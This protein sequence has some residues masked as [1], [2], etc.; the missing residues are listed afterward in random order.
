M[1]SNGRQMRVLAWNMDHW[2]RR[3][4]Q[5]EAAW[6]FLKQQQPAVALLQEA[7]P[8]ERHRA[9]VYNEDTSAGRRSWGTAV[10]APG[11]PIDAVTSV[12]VTGKTFQLIGT[13][14]G[15]LAI[16]TV[17][18]PS[19]G[20]VT[21]VSIY[22]FLDQGWAITSMHHLLSDLAPLLHARRN[23]LLVM[24]GDLN[25]STQLSKPWRYYHRN[26]FERIELFGMVNLL[27]ATAPGRR[28]LRD[29]PGEDE[30]CQHVQTHQHP[31]SQVP[32]HNDYLYATRKLAERLTACGVV[33]AGDP[34]WSLSDHRPV[35]ADFA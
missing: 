15:S 32:W 6:Q 16:A 23:D 13:Y 7:S 9:A 27:G 34:P 21:C 20:I 10:L 35:V 28:A 31:R 33:E 25:A 14:P 2:K 19:F 26:L 8:P 12:Q 4:D 18:V 24:G 3:A 29:C 1:C 17:D 11:L 22:G 5:R 30:P